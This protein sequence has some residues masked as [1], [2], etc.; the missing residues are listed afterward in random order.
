LS[1]YADGRG[2]VYID[3]LG[4][5]VD[6]ASPLSQLKV[7]DKVEM[8][9]SQLANYTIVVTTIERCSMLQREGQKR[10]WKSDGVTSLQNCD[11]FS[12]VRWLRMI[13]DEGH[14]LGHFTSSISKDASSFINCLAAERRWILSGTPTTGTNSG[15]AIKQI[16]RLLSF[17]RHPKYGNAPEKWI[18]EIERPFTHNQSQIAFEQL[19]GILKSILIRHR[20][21]DLNLHEPIRKNVELEPLPDI[22]DENDDHI[23]RIDRAKA[24]Y[25]M[26]VL[27]EKMKEWRTSYLNSKRRV[28]DSIFMKES[29]IRRPKFI[30]FSKYN[31]DLQ[32]TADFLYRTLG[33]QSVCEHW[34]TY[35]S[36][37]LSRFRHSK[38]KY[39]QCPLVIS[40]LLLL[41]LLLS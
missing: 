21:K 12:K 28:S 41:L 36:L 5:I 8:T 3:G 33:D 15:E 27:K 23:R 29:T 4:D 16:Q 38:R 2:V 1:K 32:G 7:S 18:K 35:R 31:S 30:I 9:A 34:G 22:D 26:N 17:L 13:V 37:E 24:T 40:L 39:K 10:E 20:K 25:I 6:V 19:V 14:E 11:S